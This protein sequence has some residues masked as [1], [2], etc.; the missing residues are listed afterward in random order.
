MAVVPG[1]GFGSASRYEEDPPELA[2]LGGQL[3]RRDSVGGGCAA[4]WLRGAEAT[5]GLRRSQGVRCVAGDARERAIAQVPVLPRQAP[6]APA[7]PLPPARLGPRRPSARA[8]SGSPTPVHSRTQDGVPAAGLLP[9]SPPA[10]PR[11]PGD[12]SGRLLAGASL[13]AALRAARPD[14]PGHSVAQSLRNGFLARAGPIRTY[15][16]RLRA[17]ALE[18]PPTVAGRRREVAALLIGLCHGFATAAGAFVRHGV[19]LHTALHIGLA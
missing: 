10:R 7:R 18:P 16:A 11:D 15:L 12:L 13:L 4:A 6:A 5:P 2:A 8:S 19:E 17:R 1:V 9:A 3:V 14:A